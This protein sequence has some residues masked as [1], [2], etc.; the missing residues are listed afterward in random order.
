MNNNI[1]KVRGDP[2]PT[3]W[4]GPLPPPSSYGVR[5]DPLPTPWE[6]PLPTPSSYG[7]RGDPLPTPWEGPLPTPWEDPLPT[8]GVDGVSTSSMYDAFTKYFSDPV[9]TKIKDVERYTMYMCKTYCLLSTEYRYIIALVPKDINIIG[10]KKNLNELRWLSL[11]TRSLND[12]HNLPQHYYVARRGSILDSEIYR[13]KTEDKAST[14]KCD[15]FPI[16]IT[17]LH[18]K[19]K[20][21]YQDKGIIIT[22]LETYQTIIVIE[23]N[24]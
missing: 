16:T 10:F 5:G 23:N 20:N 13:I 9:M 17:L 24:I 14:Y 18:S 21:D 3:P 22:A 11:Q 1:K 15:R 8:P 12:N 2:L 19:S 6:G 4:E 7:V